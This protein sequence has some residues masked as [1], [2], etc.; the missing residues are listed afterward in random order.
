M[1]SVRVL[2]ESY[3]AH[4]GIVGDPCPRGEGL[5]VISLGRIWLVQII[6]AQGSKGRC[7]YVAKLEKGTRKY[8][9]CYTTSKYGRCA[10]AYQLGAGAR[11]QVRSSVMMSSVVCR[12]RDRWNWSPLR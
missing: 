12:A 6:R 10:E 7:R 2:I 1:E 4:E 8:L 9:L 11:V 5:F 3:F